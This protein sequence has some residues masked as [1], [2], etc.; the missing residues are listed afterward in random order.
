MGKPGCGKSNLIAYLLNSEKA[1]YKCFDKVLF[2]TPST[3]P[4]DIILNEDNST[5]K[6]DSNWIL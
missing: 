2:I 1:Y 4:G 5:K 3:L 6:L